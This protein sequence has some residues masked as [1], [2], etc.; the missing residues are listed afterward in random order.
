MRAT[1]A[2]K[3]RTIRERMS[4][5]SEMAA[6]SI[7]ERMSLPSVLLVLGFLIFLCYPALIAMLQITG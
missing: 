2:A 5:E 4:A 7:T 1:V 3:A 6:A